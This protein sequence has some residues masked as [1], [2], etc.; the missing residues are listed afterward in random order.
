LDKVLN[1]QH[2]FRSMP[3]QKPIKWFFALNQASPSFDH[4]AEMARVAVHSAQK[5]TSLVPHFIYDGEENALTDFLRDRGVSI[6]RCRTFLYDQL[7][8]L[9]EKTGR[10][11][12]LWIGAGTFLRTELPRLAA[13]SGITDRHVLYTDCDVM[14]LAEVCDYFG[15]LDPFYFAVGPE[16][17]PDDYRNMNAGVMLMNL[18]NLAEQDVLFKAHLVRNLATLSESTWDQEAY[19]QF[20]GRAWPAKPRWDRLKKEYNWKPYWGAASTARLVHFHGP[21]PCHRDSIRSGKAPEV[22]KWL[23]KG[24]YLE[25]CDK[26][27]ELLVEAQ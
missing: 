6:I 19:K 27:D 22:F 7:G 3:D 9:A 21:K 12:I 20:Y 16:V 24:S 1:I 2:N 15:A 23:A 13:E 17:K 25:M 14:F 18:H 11:E 4:Y 8:D 5:H 26:W 10:P